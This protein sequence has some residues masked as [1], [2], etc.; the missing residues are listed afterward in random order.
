MEDEETNIEYIKIILLHTQAEV[1]PVDCG[2]KLRDLYGQI[3]SFDL[4]LLDIR[5]PD[6]N[7]YELVKE[8]KA[9]R[10]ALPIIAQTAYAMSTDQKK[11]EEAGCDNYI[12][13]PIRKEQLLELLA[14][15]L[16]KEVQKA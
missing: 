10:P 12:S 5:L 13:K 6:A 11:S 8:I 14:D 1:V 16:E 9:I 2:K 4:I 3:D 15:Y 7:G